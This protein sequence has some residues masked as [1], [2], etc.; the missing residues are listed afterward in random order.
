MSKVA[1]IKH[2]IKYHNKLNKVD[3][4]GNLNA[5]EHNLLFAIICGMYGKDSMVFDLEAL[6]RL[7][8]GSATLI[9][10][11]KMPILVD[12]IMKNVFHTFV[13]EKQGNKIVNVHLFRAMNH[14]VDDSNNLVGL[15][16]V[17]DK[18]GVEIFGRQTGGNITLADYDIF[19]NIRSIYT[20]TIFRMLSQFKSTGY[21]KFEYDRFLELIGS[22]KSFKQENIKSRILEPSVKVIGDYFKGLRYNLVKEIVDG[23]KKIKWIEFIFNKIEYKNITE[24]S[25]S[26]LELKGKDF[27]TIKRLKAAIEE[28]KDLDSSAEQA[29]ILSYLE[30][31]KMKFWQE[32][33]LYNK[34]EECKKEQ[35]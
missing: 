8:S 31:K 15:E 3:G 23:K 25:I 35:K 7:A 2:P 30:K 11:E 6:R 5:I 17:L 10:K 9:R 12:G 14:L 21:A 28:V 16:V 4:F 27:K 13:S 1:M 22:P 19:V 34:I 26:E 29:I 18:D 20:K 24:Q 32:K 33:G